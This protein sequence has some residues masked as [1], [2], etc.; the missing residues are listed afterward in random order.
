[1]ICFGTKYSHI[2][3]LSVCYKQPSGG[4]RKI[5]KRLEAIRTKSQFLARAQVAWVS[6]ITWLREKAGACFLAQ[7]CKVV[8]STS[9]SFLQTKQG[10]SLVLR[11]KQVLLYYKWEFEGQC[12]VL[13]KQTRCAWFL[14]RP[15]TEYWTMACTVMAWT[16]IDIL[17]ISA[18][19]SKSKSF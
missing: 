18:Y 10:T 9:H 2:T 6:C 1:M 19:M 16:T 5:S 8:L 3:F 7:L 12:Q 17:S 11:L 13:V 4:S 15:G 14:S